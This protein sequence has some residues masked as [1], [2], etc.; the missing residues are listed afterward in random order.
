M[1]SA[2]D[3]QGL[4]DGTLDDED[5]SAKYGISTNL[6]SNIRNINLAKQ[7]FINRKRKADQIAE[8][9]RERRAAKA[10]AAK[11][12]EQIMAGQSYQILLVEI[13]VVMVNSGGGGGNV[14]TSGGDTYGGAAYGYNEA[15]KNRFLQNGGELLI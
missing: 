1:V 13:W 14:T 9:E 5:I 4:I 7:N 6:T 12:R 11:R 15:E 2:Q 8:F 10:A 3:I